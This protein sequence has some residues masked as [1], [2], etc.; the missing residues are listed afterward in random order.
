MSKTFKQEYLE[1][2]NEKGWWWYC[3]G[4]S[5]TPMFVDQDKGIIREMVGSTETNMPISKLKGHWQKIIRPGNA[6]ITIVPPE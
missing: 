5:M 4:Q 6:T 2:P 3:D 1:H